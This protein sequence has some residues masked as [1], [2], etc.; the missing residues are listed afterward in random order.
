MKKFDEYRFAGLHLHEASNK[1]LGIRHISADG[2]KI[3][4][5]VGQAHLCPT[6]FGYA[7]ILDQHHVVFIKD[8]QVGTTWFLEGECPVV[9][10]DKAYWKVREFGDWSEFFGDE[11]KMHDFAEWAKVA[12]EQAS[13]DDDELRW[14]KK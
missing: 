1:Y 5:R 4:L 6:K 13:V 11:P 3:A 12:Q 2:N 9:V 8:W 7:L 10:L 14:R